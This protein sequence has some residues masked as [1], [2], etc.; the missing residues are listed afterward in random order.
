LSRSAEWQRRGE[1]RDRL[2]AEVTRARSLRTLLRALPQA[3]SAALGRRL[4]RRSD[5]SRE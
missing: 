5:E 1:E 4:R 2:A 3:A